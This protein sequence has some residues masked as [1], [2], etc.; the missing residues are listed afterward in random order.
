MR[1][2]NLNLFILFFLCVEL[3]IL[4]FFSLEVN[5]TFFALILVSVLLIK[6]A[7]L[8]HFVRTIY[9]IRWFLIFSMI[10]FLFLTPPDYFI[11]NR[12]AVFPLTHFLLR[13]LSIVLIVNII[14][15]GFNDLFLIT[16]AL[17]LYKK[18]KSKFIFVI[19]PFSILV[20]KGFHRT[21]KNKVLLFRARRSFSISGIS[22]VLFNTVKCFRDYVNTYMQNLKSRKIEVIDI[23][24]SVGVC[25]L[26]ILLVISI[27]T[28]LL[29][30]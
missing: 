21:M 28:G 1:K 14:L 7:I 12:D 30:I 25:I 13:I 17:N 22:D 6:A 8:R 11:F 27:N 24:L 5:F 19:I 23:K 29:M 9:G 10:V 2:F 3:V 4:N 20:I 26:I 16:I 15:Y 18:I